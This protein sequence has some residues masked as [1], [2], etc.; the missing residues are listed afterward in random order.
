MKHGNGLNR[1]LCILLAIALA[2]GLA[3]CSS[4]SKQERRI[5][6]GAGVD[7]DLSGC[8]VEQETDTHGGFLGDG[9]TCW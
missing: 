5:S 9:N 7:L 6:K 1:L 4:L 8:R 3:S 2:L